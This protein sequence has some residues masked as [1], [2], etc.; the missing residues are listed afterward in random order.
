MS[1][2]ISSF[3]LQ[4]A[5]EAWAHFRCPSWLKTPTE[6]IPNTPSVSVD[7]SRWKV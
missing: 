2:R 4:K 3:L 5:E 1:R 7:V 6:L